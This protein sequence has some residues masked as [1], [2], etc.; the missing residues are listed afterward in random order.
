MSNLSIV[1]II[2]TLFVSFILPLAFLVGYALGH[3]KQGI[4]SAWLLGALGFF[5]PQILIRLPILT[6]LSQ[7]AGFAAFAQ[8]H[9]VAYGFGLAFTAGLF[10]LAGRYA[11]ARCL[12]KNLTCRRALAAGLGHGGI[13][14][15]L[16]TGLAYLSNVVF[17]VML[18]T[19]GFEAAIAQTTAAGGD[20]TPLLTAKDALMNTPWTMFLL[21]GYERLLAMTCHVAMSMMVCY[22]VHTNRVLPWTLGCLAVHTCMDFIASISLF[23]GRG[24]T[25]AAA[26]TI[27]YILLTAI[28]VLSILILQNIRTRWAAETVQEV[29]YDSQA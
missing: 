14:A 6:G 15:I 19:G 8:N 1:S 13:E 12:K 9:P 24:L 2:V 22:G 11:V 5:V 26:Y 27:I 28:T 17:L 21:A 25:L 7:S 16:I 10:E 4:W 18:Q 3:K 29:P 23:I 20:V